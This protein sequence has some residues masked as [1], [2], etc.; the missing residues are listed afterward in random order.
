MFYEH[1]VKPGNLV[2]EINTIDFFWNIK[3]VF[4][5]YDVSFLQ[6]STKL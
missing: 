4:Y 2:V 3:K 6:M 5:G 1:G